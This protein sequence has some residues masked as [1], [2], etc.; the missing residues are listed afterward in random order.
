METISLR[1]PHHKFGK[2]NLF[3]QRNKK[4]SFDEYKCEYC[5]LKGKRYG[6]GSEVL[7]VRKAKV[8]THKAEPVEQVNLGK[9][10]ITHDH[11]SMFGFEKGK[12]YDRVSCP[13]EFLEKYSDDIWL[14]SEE[15]K[16]AVRM[17]DHEAKRVE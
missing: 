3:T 4:G 10:L 17:L 16:E 5:G 9:A 15:R 2:V 14:Y 6:I 12:E 11:P 7:Q 1:D 8:C 13:V